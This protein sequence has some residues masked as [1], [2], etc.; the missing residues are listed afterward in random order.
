MANNIRQ[1]HRDAMEQADLGLAARQLGHDDQA[2]RYFHRAYELEAEAANTL[3]GSLDAEPTRSVLF[4]SAATLALD[5]NL[6]IEAEKLVCAA[7]LGNPPEQIAEELR[8]VLEQINFRRHLTL[9]GVELRPDEVQMSIAGHAVGY[10]VAPADAFLKRVGNTETLLY[11]TAER[12]R[13]Q[14]YR[15]SGRRNKSLT[16]SLQLYLSVPRA[17]SF[18]ITL[19]VGRQLELPSISIG[20]EVIDE[21]LDCLEI[22]SQGDDERLRDRIADEA[23][24]RNFI[25][26]ARTIQPDGARIGIVGFTSVRRGVSREVSLTSTPESA[27]TV[28]PAKPVERSEKKIKNEA[29]TVQ[30]SGIL[31]FADSR[32]KVDQIQIV[33]EDNSRHTVLVPEG[34]MND[35][36]RPLWDT[37]VTVNGER[38]GNKVHLMQIRP[39]E[40]E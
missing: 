2:L 23:Y 28:A 14:P 25:G 16:E 40:P 15:D 22:Y 11:R 21:F 3:A 32:T 12:K 35:I 1:A 6:Y 39:T 10:G 18:A 36:V 33:A 5:C 30:I 4:R 8:D 34:M 17:A 37:E 19:K 29:E 20:E 26:L 24:Y 7:L 38:K 27:L 9:R 31:K 13:R